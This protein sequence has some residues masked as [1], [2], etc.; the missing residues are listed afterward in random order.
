MNLRNLKNNAAKAEFVKFNNSS[1]I[2]NN[3]SAP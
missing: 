1:N 2:N 3:E